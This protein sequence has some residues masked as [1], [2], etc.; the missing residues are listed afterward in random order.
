MEMEESPEVAI[1]QHASGNSNITAPNPVL[2]LTILL[3]VMQVINTIFEDGITYF[4]K[5]ALNCWSL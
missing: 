5:Y 2:P 1:I 3:G 4:T